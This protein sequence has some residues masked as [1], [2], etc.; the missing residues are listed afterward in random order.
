[1]QKISRKAH[2]IISGSCLLPFVFIAF[3]FLFPYVYRLPS[4][5]FD[6]ETIVHKTLNYDKYDI[7]VLSNADLSKITGE[8]KLYANVWS[9]QKRIHNYYITYLDAADEYSL[10][11]KDITVLSDTGELMVE[12][13]HDGR[14]KS[15]TGTDLYKIAEGSSD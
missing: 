13:T 2:M 9:N 11:I 14:S 8:R 12:F 4:L 15:G 6:P 7:V 5:Q 1:M 3:G 10:R